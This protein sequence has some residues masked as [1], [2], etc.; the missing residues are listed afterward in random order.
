MEYIRARGG[1][2]LLRSP[3][4]AIGPKQDRIGVLAGAG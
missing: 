1:E 4:T 2:V 3:V